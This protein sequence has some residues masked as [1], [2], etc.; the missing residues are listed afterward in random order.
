MA[1]NS[2]V[3]KLEKM[4][5]AAIREKADLPK[6]PTPYF[7]QKQSC[8][9]WLM[10]SKKVISKLVAHKVAPTCLDTRLFSMPVS[11]VRLL[12][13]PIQRQA[14]QRMLSGVTAQE[15][16]RFSDL[17]DWFSTSAMV[18]TSLDFCLNNFRVD[19]QVYFFTCRATTKPNVD[20]KN[21]GR[22]LQ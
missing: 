19:I 9:L 22:L 6:V 5:K 21:M 18:G 20:T 13:S 4:A 14:P 7:S 12:Q 2:A 1:T 10:Y 8:L 3:M 15:Q 17:R 16:G 11:R